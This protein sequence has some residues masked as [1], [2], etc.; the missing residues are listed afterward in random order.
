MIVYPE[1][2]RF[3]AVYFDN[4]G[5]VIH[6]V[7]SFPSNHAVTFES[8][9]EPDAPRY[10]LDYEASAESTVIVKFS[11]ALPGQAFR[12]YIEGKSKRE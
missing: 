4:E 1:G 3:R 6:Y 7:V 2:S 9:Q 8:G 11:V 5:H 12:T 10:R